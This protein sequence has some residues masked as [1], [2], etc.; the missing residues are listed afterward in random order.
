MDEDNPRNSEGAFI[1]INENE[2]LFVYSKFTEGDKDYSASSIVSVRSYDEGTTWTDFSEIRTEFEGSSDLMS[3]SLLRLGNGNI[4]L[5]YLVR[6]SMDETSIIMQQSSDNGHT[7]SEPYKCTTRYGY[8]VVNNDR[9]IMT[10]SHRIIIPAAEH[11]A[12]YNSKGEYSYLSPGIVAFFI[13]DDDGITWS[14]VNSPITLDVSISS[15]GLQEPGVIELSENNLWGWVR[16]DLGRQ[17]EFFS[18]DNGQSWTLATPS[19]FTSP[20]SPMSMKRLYDGGIIAVWNPIPLNN[21][22]TENMITKGRSPLVYS[23]SNDNG[24]T[25]HNPVIIEDNEEAGFCYTA[26]YSNTENIIL[27]AYSAGTKDDGSC[28]NRMRIR[29]LS[30]G[31]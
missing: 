10:S 30:F 31:E 12:V 27:L 2:I 17:Y 8:F 13:S 4:G 28:M 20:R 6:Y 3:V 26:I 18:Y 21:I 1:D 5:F 19:R 29:T 16:T 24:N 11:E 15:S 23:I 25:W 9:V 14:E 22:T 7:W